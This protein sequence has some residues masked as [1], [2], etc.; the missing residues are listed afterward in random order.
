MDLNEM[1]RSIGLR[2]ERRDG[3]IFIA[4][5]FLVIITMHIVWY[6]TDLSFPLFMLSFVPMFVFVVLKP[7]L[8]DRARREPSVPAAPAAATHDTSVGTLVSTAIGLGMAAALPFGLGLAGWDALIWLTERT[9]PAGDTVLGFHLGD[10]PSE[11]VGGAAVLVAAA[12][13]TLPSMRRKPQPAGST[14]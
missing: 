2:V 10:I 8:Y 4:L 9:L 1:R 3:R 14:Q 12:A 11:A 13:W 6:T 7:N 5:T